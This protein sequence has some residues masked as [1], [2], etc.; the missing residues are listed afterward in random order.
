MWWNLTWAMEK[1]ENFHFDGLLLWKECNVWAKTI[2]RSCV[3]KKDFW[4]QNWRNLFCWTKACQI[5]TFWTFHCLSEVIEIPVIFETSFCMPKLYTILLY[6]SY[7]IIVK[8]TLNFFE[9]SIQSIQRSLNLLFE[10]YLFL[11]F[12]HF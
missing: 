3:V 8:C 12:P 6:L 9:T 2:Q 10:C 5:S 1:S 7:N 4:F 11:I